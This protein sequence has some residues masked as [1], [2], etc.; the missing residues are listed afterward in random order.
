VL[1][2]EDKKIKKVLITVDKDK[3][4]VLDPPLGRK[5]GEVETGKQRRNTRPISEIFLLLSWL[6]LKGLTTYI[7][8]KTPGIRSSNPERRP[9]GAWA[10]R[11]ARM[12]IEITILRNT[13]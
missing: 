11:T 7:Y 8:Q 2:R 3:K 9:R 6:P 1:I 5:S 12:A 13:H 4:I 10:I